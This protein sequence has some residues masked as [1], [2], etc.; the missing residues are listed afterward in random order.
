MAS[1]PEEP[2]STNPETQKQEEPPKPKPKPQEPVAQA[3]PSEPA[4]EKKEGGD[5]S[6]QRNDYPR[7]DRPNHKRRKRRNEFRNGRNHMMKLQ[8]KNLDYVV[9]EYQLQQMLEVVAPVEKV[10]IDRADG[11]RSAGSATVMALGRHAMS[12]VK[13][14]QG[15]PV[16]FRNMKISIVL[17]DMAPPRRRSYVGERDYNGGGKSHYNGYDDYRSEKSYKNDY[18]GGNDRGGYY[19]NSNGSNNYRDDKRDDD[20]DDR[21]DYH[22]KDRESFYEDRT[23]D[24]AYHDDN[25]YDNSKGFNSSNVPPPTTSISEIYRTDTYRPHGNV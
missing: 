12:I 11:G 3:A 19:N 23:G 22:S 15:M 8:I 14:F 18:R 25:H 16:Q 6:E 24:Y 17:A 1:M 7:V 4:N 5:Y 2:V 20:Y 21:R 13:A 10:M 9:T